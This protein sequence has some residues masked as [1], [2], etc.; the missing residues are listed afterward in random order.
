MSQVLDKQNHFGWLLSVYF[1]EY[2]PY[3]FHYLS[4]VYARKE[5]EYRTDDERK[6]RESEGERKEAGKTKAKEKGRKE[7][8]S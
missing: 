7:E 5:K 1:R 3:K 6:R 8:G 2:H 4:L